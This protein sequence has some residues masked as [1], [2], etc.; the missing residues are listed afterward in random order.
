MADSTQLP[1]TLPPAEAWT[2]PRHRQACTRDPNL[3]PGS[4]WHW[5]D[6]CPNAARR[7]CYLLHMR[8]QKMTEASR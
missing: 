5:W 6:G 3:G 8:M 7:G 1:L 4:C 2:R